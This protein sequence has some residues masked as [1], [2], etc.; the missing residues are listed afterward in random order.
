VSIPDSGATGGGVLLG[1]VVS[2]GI[3]ASLG[4]FEPQDAVSNERLAARRIN[5]R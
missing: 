4:R 5:R 2:T 3:E 1:S